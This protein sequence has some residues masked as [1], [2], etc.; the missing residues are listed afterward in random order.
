MLIPK[1]R[2]NRA[3]QKL[4]DRM[5]HPKLVGADIYVARLSNSSTPI[6]QKPMVFADPHNLGGP[7]VAGPLRTGSLHDELTCKTSKENAPTVLTD[8]THC[9]RTAVDSR[10]CYRCISHMHSVGIK[11]VFWT[12]SDGK[13]E[14]AKVR[15]LVNALEGNRGGHGVAS[16]SVFVT[17]HEVL[18]L[19]RMMAS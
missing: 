16:P 3:S 15:D 18:M 12:N 13:W 10:P 6:P 9:V 19:R 2:V 11:R 14:V 7:D 4:R 8:D 5:K 17:K 1:N